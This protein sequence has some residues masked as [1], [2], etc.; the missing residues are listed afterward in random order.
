MSDTQYSGSGHMS[1]WYSFSDSFKIVRPLK[2]PATFNEYLD[3]DQYYW[4]VS[5]DGSKLQEAEN[6]GGSNGDIDELV[7][8]VDIISKQGC[9]VSG[10]SFY[11][12]EEPLHCS[13]GFVEIESNVVTDHEFGTVLEI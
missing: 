7:E 9:V 11:Q 3:S 4:V 1:N 13:V 5:A 10:L 2:E 6:I 12:S 8:I